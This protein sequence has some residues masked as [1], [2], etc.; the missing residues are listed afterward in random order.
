MQNPKQKQDIGYNNMAPSDT[1]TS[2]AKSPSP[3]A[4]LRIPAD[5]FVAVEDE[6][7]GVAPGAAVW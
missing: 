7:V 3:L 5:F 4:E 2:P 6:E 1:N